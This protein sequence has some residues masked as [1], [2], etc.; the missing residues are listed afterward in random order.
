M[1]ART[2]R[3]GGN[4]AARLVRSVPWQS[5]GRSARSATTRLSQARSSR[6]SR[7]RTT[8]SG[9]SSGKSS[10]DSS[11]YNVVHLTLPD[12]EEE[13]AASLADWRERGVLVR[14]QSRRAGGSRRSTSAPTAS[15][16]VARGFVAALR[17]RAVREPRRPAARA[18]ARRARR[19]AACACSRRRARSSSRSSCSGT[20]RSSSTGS[21]SRTSRQRG[22]RDAR[23]WR[24]DAEFGDALTEELADAQLLIADGHHR[25]ETTLAF[26]EEDGGGVAW[27]MVVIVPTD[28]EGLTIFPTHRVAQIGERRQRDADR[29]AGRR[30]A[31]ARALPRRAAT[32]CS[33]A[34]GSTRRSST[35][36]APQGVTYTPHASEAIAAVDRGEAEAA[37]LLRADAHR[38]RVGDRGPRRRD[39][40]E[41]HVLL[42]EAHLRPALA[43][44]CDRLARSLPR[45]RRGRG[46]RARASCRPA[47]SASR[48]SAQG[49]GGDDTTAI[50]QAAE[51]AILARFRDLDVHDRLG[52]VGRVGDGR[53]ARRRRPDRRL[54]EREARHPVLLALDRVRRRR[55][56]GRRRSSATSTTSAPA[57]SGSARRGEGATAERRA[58]RRRQAEGR[59]RDPLLRGDAAP[60]SSRATRR[61]SPASPTGCGSW[62]RSRSRSAISPRAASTPSAR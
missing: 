18:H 26:H 6:S 51:D 21:A 15:S 52:G 24:L 1:V 9:R 11:P 12:S 3:R 19:R 39:A 62:A 55:D 50:D 48:S 5:Y 58:A 45:R 41:E 46:A 35:R 40:A 8:S 23:L 7:P 61:R 29:P 57:R 20:A 37:F 47:S 44:R 14:T 28:Q 34:T 10:A 54:A 31:R 13:A 25:Y 17:A 42:S 33:R 4:E 60:R 56:D 2:S 59:D 43:T 36:L 22:R 16:A 49:A 30:A 53:D 32:S 38:G 27:M